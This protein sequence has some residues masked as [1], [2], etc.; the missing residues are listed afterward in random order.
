MKALLLIAALS[1]VVAGTLRHF[2]RPAATARPA[3]PAADTAALGLPLL[4]GPPTW[5]VPAADTAATALPR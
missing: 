1:S 4:V 2:G 5:P 3:R